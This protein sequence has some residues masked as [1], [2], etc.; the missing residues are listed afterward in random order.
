VGADLAYVVTAEE[1]ALPIKCYGPEL[2]VLPVY[3]IGAFDDA[4]SDEERRLL[5]DRSIA[6]VGFEWLQ[7]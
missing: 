4:A 7:S 5:V 1:A 3:S 2:M 6:Q